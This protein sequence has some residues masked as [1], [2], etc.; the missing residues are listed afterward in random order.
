MPN[1]VPGLREWYGLEGNFVI[2]ANTTIIAD[3]DVEKE[4]ARAIICF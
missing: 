4:A 1:V 3:N 2:D